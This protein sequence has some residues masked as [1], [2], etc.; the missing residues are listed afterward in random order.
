VQPLPAAPPGPAHAA[1]V[2]DQCKVPFDDLG[3]ELERRASDAGQQPG[4]VVDDGAAGIIVPMPAQEAITLRLGDAGL[5]Q[6]SSSAFS[7]SREW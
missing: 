5:P 6:P 7:V 4:P 2:K 3:T 1:A